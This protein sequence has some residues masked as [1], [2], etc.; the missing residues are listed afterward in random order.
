MRD[1]ALHLNGQIRGG[2]VVGKEDSVGVSLQVRALR[3]H[4][5]VISQSEGLE[6]G[7]ESLE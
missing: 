5:V 7:T 2:Q 4:E 6:H 3:F 1:F